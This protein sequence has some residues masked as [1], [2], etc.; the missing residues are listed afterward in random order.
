M[1]GV[2]RVWGPRMPLPLPISPEDALRRIIAPALE[3]LPAKMGSDEALVMLVAIALQESGLTTRLQNGGPARGLFMFERGGGVHGVLNHP[4]VRADARKL[5]ASRGCPSTDNSV[6]LA[7]AGDD[8][9][10][11]GFARLLL[12]TDPQA[13]PDIGDADG[14]WK[15]YIRTWRPGKPRPLHWPGNHSL[16]VHIVT[17]GAKSDE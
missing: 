2:T 5:C 16:A 4:A 6:Y 8:V 14:A 12:W 11:A 15:L 3:L 1:S 17:G 7:L 9:L 10:A 13:L